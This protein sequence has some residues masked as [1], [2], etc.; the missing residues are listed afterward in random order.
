MV[1]DTYI[2]M[3]NADYKPTNIT[4]RGPDSID[5]RDYIDVRYDTHDTY[6]MYDMYDDMYDMY[7]MYDSM[8]CMICMNVCTYVRTYVRTYVCM[9]GWI[10]R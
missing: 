1:Y 9:D 3:V 5:I 10:D 2:T 8:I 6:D 4:G 7:D